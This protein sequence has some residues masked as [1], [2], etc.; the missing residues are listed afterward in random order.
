M[1]GRYRKSSNAG[2]LILTAVVAVLGFGGLAAALYYA[3]TFAPAPPATV[4]RK[5]SPPPAV[6][7]RPAP[8]VAEKPAEP[9][10]APRRK[11]T[12][13]AKRDKPLAE[14]KRPQPTDGV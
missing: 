9:P 12:G 7:P 11:W 6:T 8:A 5:A 14:V 3:G 10:P 2:V 4:A 1:S 13:A